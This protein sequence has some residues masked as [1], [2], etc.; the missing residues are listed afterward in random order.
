LNPLVI[1]LIG[2]IVV[3]GGILALRLHAFLALILG[4][5]IVAALTPSGRIRENGIA[6][7]AVPV[8]E[9]DASG[10]VVLQP[11]KGQ[12][13]I[14]GMVHVLRETAPDEK[15]VDTL[16]ARLDR[17]GTIGKSVVVTLRDGTARVLP[18]AGDRVVH[19]T[20]I[21]AASAVAGRSIGERVAAGFGNTALK[22][23]ILIAM[24]AIIG[25]AERVV[26]AAQSLVGE[27]RTPLAFLGS[28]FTLG[29]PVFFDTV[30][31]LL[32][33]LGKAM[34]VRTGRNYVLYILCI[35][36]SA[37]MAHSLVPPTPGPL[38]VAAELGVDVG[39]MMIGGLAIGLFT[40]ASGYLY[41]LWANA[42]WDI[43]LRESA[44]LTR[45]EL[46][47]MQ[48][49]DVSMLPALWLSLMPIV[50][51]VVLIAGG[52]ILK[53]AGSQ[54]GLSWAQT[55]MPVVDVLGNKNIA[56]IIAAMV[57]LWLLS[58]R[59]YGP[60]ADLRKSVQSA[61]ES[62]GV[63]ILVTAA[64]GAFGHVL[65]QTGIAPYLAALLGGGASSAW[66][67][68]PLAFGITT[69]VRIAQGSATVAMI[70]AVGVVAPLAAT[71][72][73]G[74]HPL[75]LALAIGC[76]SKPISWMNDSGFWIIGKMS[77]MTE[78]ET[79]K[80]ASAMMAIMGVV[81]LIVTMIAAT[82]LPLV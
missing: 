54:Y 82:I 27:K 80:T 78:G 33:P 12:K 57:A 4:A 73:L 48:Q 45:E 5:L 2:M 77:G 35:V 71:M 40:V 18:Q 3:V 53:L 25:K 62:G 11:G 81:G 29:V 32:M 19:H 20:Q 55:L 49:R 67:M 64:G 7:A 23:G 61:L 26:V 42:R 8:V 24:A 41:A 37:T 63:I 38:F 13:V 70:T 65:Q 21:N 58:R 51:P 72:D 9:V 43:P 17:V 68:L 79:L 46:D 1:L 30:F 59:K 76:G 69:L 28:G 36:A 66:L 47:A 75:Y 31:Y 34:R 44:E 56:L 39:V 14:E 60:P 10:A 52:T 15:P 16:T 74:F 6:A 22:I 50:L